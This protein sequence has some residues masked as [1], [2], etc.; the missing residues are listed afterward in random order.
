[1]PGAKR[2]YPQRCAQCG[3]DFMHNRPKRT[4]SRECLAAY[5]RAATNEKWRPG[6]AL[7]DLRPRPDADARPSDK[8][9]VRT[10]PLAPVHD[11]PEPIAY[12]PVCLELYCRRHPMAGRI[13][14]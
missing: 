6:G 9:Y 5:Q 7:K 12:C 3:G 14:P 2:P 1:M 10:E 8:L 11:V 13:V 4:C